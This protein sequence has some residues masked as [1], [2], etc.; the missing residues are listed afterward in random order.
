MCYLHLSLNIES[1]SLVDVPVSTNVEMPLSSITPLLP[2]PIP[3]IQPQQQTHVPTPTIVPSTSLQNLLTFGSLFNFEDRVKAL[4]DNFSEFQ[5]TNQF[6]AA[7]SSIPSIVDTYLANK[8]NEAVKI[9]V[10]L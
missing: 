7:I 10:Q 8:M 4:E 2:P 9:V 5:Q 3:F 6:A 1:T